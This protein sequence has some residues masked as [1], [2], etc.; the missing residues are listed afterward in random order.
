[1]SRSFRIAAV[2]RGCRA[3]CPR[4]ANAATP[5]RIIARIF[6]LLTLANPAQWRCFVAAAA[7]AA[8]AAACVNPTS[9]PTT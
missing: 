8:A 6:Q 5:L 2:A 3:D 7:A 1:M 9:A 4:C